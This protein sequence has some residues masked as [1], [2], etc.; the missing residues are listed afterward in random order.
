MASI[1]SQRQAYALLIIGLISL[2]G[3]WLLHPDP[4]SYPIGV[5]LFGV[6]MLIAALLNPARLVIA[7]SLTT[8]IGI[9]LFLGF[10]RLIPGG[11]IFPAFIFAIGVGLLAIA[12]AARR[13]YVGRGAL[14]PAIIVLVA[15]LIEILL[16]AHL[17][18]S[19]LIPFALSLWFPGL[20]L[21]V[22]GI[23]YFFFGRE[24]GR[25]S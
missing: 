21:L 12:F 20:G 19:G 6:G 1:N 25:K 18:P 10:K 24:P 13:G 9:A 7:S 3:A 11:Q 5:L 23:L 4:Y 8:A 16:A 17:T 14:S 2:L 15:G 22:L